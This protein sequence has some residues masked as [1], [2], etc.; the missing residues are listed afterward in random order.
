MWSTSLSTRVEG[1]VGL[2]ALDLLDLCKLKWDKRYW[3]DI[4]QWRGKIASPLPNMK[5][6]HTTRCGP[7]GNLGR[8]PELSNLSKDGNFLL[9]PTRA[10]R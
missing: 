3:T 10:L 1:N 2:C 6:P 8:N 9:Y 4:H 5:Q 7:G